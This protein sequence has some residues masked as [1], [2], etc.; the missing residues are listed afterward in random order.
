MT[1]I[2]NLLTTIIAFFA[3]LFTKEATAPASTAT[4][5]AVQS[6]VMKQRPLTASEKQRRA[7]RIRLGRIDGG[8]KHYGSKREK[9]ANRKY[10]KRSGRQ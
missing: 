9:G 2:R 5:A 10:G 6:Q 7:L 4:P 3:G 1:A 8:G